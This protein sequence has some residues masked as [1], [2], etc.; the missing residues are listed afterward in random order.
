MDDPRINP[1][2]A[3]RAAARLSGVALYGR[4]G[5]ALAVRVTLEMNWARPTRRGETSG[6]VPAHPAAGGS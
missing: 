6:R 1:I 5:V 4:Q 2:R 3:A